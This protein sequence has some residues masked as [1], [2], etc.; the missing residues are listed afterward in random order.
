MRY[1]PSIVTPAKVTPE[2]LPHDMRAMLRA[3]TDEMARYIAV[4]GIVVSPDP[5]RVMK[6][7]KEQGYSLVK[8][9]DLLHSKNGAYNLRPAGKDID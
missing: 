4:Y 9:E 1:E 6:N 7:L 8:T 5:A 2:A 3:L